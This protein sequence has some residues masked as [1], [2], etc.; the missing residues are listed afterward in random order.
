MLGK[1]FGSAHRLQYRGGAGIETT[2]RHKTVKELRI[3]PAML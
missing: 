1:L 3:K 2:H